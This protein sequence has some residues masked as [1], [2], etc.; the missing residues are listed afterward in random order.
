MNLHK[1]NIKPSPY[2]NRDWFA[3]SVYSNQLELPNEIDHRL[4]LKLP[5]NQKDQG[6]HA[7]ACIKEWQEKMDIEY[8][9]YM[10]PQFIYNN[11]INQESDGM[12]CRDVMKILSKYGSCYENTYPYGIIES[13]DEISK[14]VYDEAKNFKIKNYAKINTID[15]LKKAFINIIYHN[16]ILYILPT[17]F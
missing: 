7:A 8:D 16:Y 10:S 5:R 17:I 12:H 14:T 11:R 4:K 2:D 1:L 9:G 3:G 15:E 13:P 6:S